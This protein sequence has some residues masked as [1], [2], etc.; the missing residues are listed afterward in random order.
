MRAVN[1]DEFFVEDEPIEAIEAALAAGRRVVT[2][3]PEEAPSRRPG[4]GAKFVVTKT[5]DGQFRFNLKAANG[6]I[7]ATSESY[8]TKAAAL[9]GI[10]SWRESASNAAVEFVTA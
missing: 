10:E 5:K 1:A 2:G 4:A 7:I 9:E 3:R 8:A 6:M